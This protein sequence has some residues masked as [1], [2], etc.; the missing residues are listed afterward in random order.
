VRQL[1]QLN[2]LPEG[3]MTI[4]VSEVAERGLSARRDQS[5]PVPVGPSSRLNALEG[6]SR[7]EVVASR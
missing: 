3:F 5:G 7:E 1:D 6:V 2:P 4:M